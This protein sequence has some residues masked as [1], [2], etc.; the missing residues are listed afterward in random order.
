M[1][2]IV[3]KEIIPAGLRVATTTSIDLVDPTYSYQ[4]ITYPKITYNNG[5]FTDFEG[6][7]IINL[8]GYQLNG[9]APIWGTNYFGF[10]LTSNRWEYGTVEN[11]GE[12]HLKWIGN[13]SIYPNLAYNTSVNRDYIPTTNWSRNITITYFGLPNSITIAGAVG[14]STIINGTY[15]KT[16]Q[17]IGYLAA[18]TN[19]SYNYYKFTIPNTYITSPYNKNSNQDYDVDFWVLAFSADGAVYYLTNPSTDK[20]SLPTVGWVYSNINGFPYPNSVG[21]SGPASLVI[22]P[23]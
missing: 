12:G 4:S 7:S 16:N 3:K 21:Q 15:S 13:P 11:Y 9:V 23:S 22:T 5:Q 1:A 2:F 8:Y 19:G 18:S 17:G 14:A 10:N 20:F 6:V